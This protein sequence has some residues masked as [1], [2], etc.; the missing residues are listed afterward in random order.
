MYTLFDGCQF[1]ITQMSIRMSTVKI[2]TNYKCL[3]HLVSNARSSQENNT[4]LIK[5][6]IASLY[7]F[8]IYSICPEKPIDKSVSLTELLGSFFLRDI[9]WFLE[10]C[11]SQ[12]VFARSQNLRSI[13]DRSGSLIFGCLCIL[14]SQVFLS[15]GL[16]F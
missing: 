2:S 10:K 15:L 14:E 6:D 3:R 4:H 9:E 13:C 7:N 11:G 8:L 5:V 1:T 16:K 12:K